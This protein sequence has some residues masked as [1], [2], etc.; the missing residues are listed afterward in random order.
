MRNYSE[1]HDGFLEGFWIDGATV[2][3]YLSTDRKERF[4]AVADGVVALSA[5]GFRAGNIVFDVL[6]RDHQE[7]AFQDI[8]ELYDLKAGAAGKSQGAKLLEEARQQ[9]LTAL[10]INSSYGGVCLVLA[11]SV[12]VLRR[13]EWAQR[14][15]RT[16]GK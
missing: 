6:T 14:Y 1:F 7:I 12:D 16:L 15:L 5:S 3:V 9:R 2:H 10:E 8:A 11:R 13:D 4:T